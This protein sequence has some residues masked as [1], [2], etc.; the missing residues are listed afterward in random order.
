[1]VICGEG[2]GREGGERERER[3]NGTHNYT[4][5][6]ATCMLLLTTYYHSDT[7]EQ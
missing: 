2:I 6:G 3:N 4:I 7:F 5:K 1:M